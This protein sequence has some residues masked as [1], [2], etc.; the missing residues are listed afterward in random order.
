MELY[1]SI[2]STYILSDISNGVAKNDELYTYYYQMYAN[3]FNAYNQ[4]VKLQDISLANT[5]E[6][7]VMNHAYKRASLISPLISCHLETSGLDAADLH[8]LFDCHSS[9]VVEG[10]AVTY[11]IAKT[12]NLTHVKPI[13]LSG[14]GG[15]EFVQCLK[16]LDKDDLFN[17]AICIS[18][19]II[20]APDTR[21]INC[22]YPLG[23][24]VSVCLI[25]TM[26]ILGRTQFK[27]RTGE[28]Q[29]D[30]LIVHSFSEETKLCASS[31]GSP[32]IVYIR[33]LFENIN[34]GCADVF[35]TLK[36]VSKKENII[37]TKGL[38]QC[39]G[40]Y[41]NSANFIVEKQVY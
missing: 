12:A 30:W 28:C 26:P 3:I 39:I 17:H 6:I 31:I 24:A 25:S 15:T 10:P 21:L 11:D 1:M 9:A 22:G 13:S 29:T 41:E 4:D 34:F 23:D 7:P 2:P 19:Q 36:E 32:K 38:L 5:R 8:Y 37:G 33:D 35:V 18:S 20:Y 14:Q 16:F 40:M 27:I